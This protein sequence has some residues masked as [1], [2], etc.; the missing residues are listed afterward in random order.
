MRHPTSDILPIIEDFCLLGSGRVITGILTGGSSCSVCSVKLCQ[1]ECD[2]LLWAS[3][4]VGKTGFE[5]LH[6]GT[7]AIV[8]L[9]VHNL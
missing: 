1:V 2:S 8:E 9:F 3:K 7:L 4:T 6:F 5:N